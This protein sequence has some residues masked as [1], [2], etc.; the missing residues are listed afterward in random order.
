[1][2]VCH[3]FTVDGLELQKKEFFDDPS[4]DPDQY[5]DNYDIPQKESH[6][7]LKLILRKISEIQSMFQFFIL[8]CPNPK[9]NQNTANSVQHKITDL[10]VLIFH[11]SH[12]THDY[13]TKGYKLIRI[14]Q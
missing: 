6:P 10:I 11:G 7:I 13:R 2:Q 4:A 12:S 14:I 3:I 9:C 1:M 5:H 8:F